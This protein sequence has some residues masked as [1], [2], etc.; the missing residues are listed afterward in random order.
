MSYN[1]SNSGT[2]KERGIEAWQKMIDDKVDDMEEFDGDVTIYDIPLPQ[3]LKRSKLFRRLPFIPPV[4]D[5]DFY[6]INLQTSSFFIILCC[7]FQRINWFQLTAFC[8][9]YKRDSTS[10]CVGG[11]VKIKLA[12]KKKKQQ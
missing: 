7:Q 1:A 10:V 9:C 11:G 12:S 5:W 2:L 6:L 4:R 3:F 8:D